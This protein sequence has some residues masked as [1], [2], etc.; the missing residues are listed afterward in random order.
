MKVLAIPEDFRNDQYILQP[1]FDRLMRHVGDRSPKVRVCRDPLLGGDG[2]ALKS[3]RIREIVEKYT[4]MI[5]LFILCVDRDGRSGRRQRLDKLEEEFGPN[6]L[7]VDAREELETWLLA[8][9]DLGRLSWQEVRTE[10]H[11]KERYFETLAESRG[12]SDTLGGGRKVLGDEASRNI[13]AIRLK[14]PEDFDVLARRL[15]AIVRA[16]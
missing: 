3:E 10:L 8:G 7:A 12:L 16:T 15:E 4:G 5:D 14:C 13:S 9:L 2:E 11:L 1:L 6:F